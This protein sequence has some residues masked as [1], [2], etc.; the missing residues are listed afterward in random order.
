M[1]SKL[2]GMMASGKPSIVTGN[3]ASEVKEVLQRSGG[4]IY[5]DS[6]NLETLI[7]AFK[8]IIDNI[9]EAASMGSKARS[10]VVNT[11][12]KQKILTNLEDQIIKT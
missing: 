5:L 2:L 9:D 7:E 3:S 4:G 12:G 11:F 1:P 10:Y 8:Y 6:D